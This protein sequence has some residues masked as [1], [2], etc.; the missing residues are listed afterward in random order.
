MSK[1][2]RE[3]H[4]RQLIMEWK[5]IPGWNN[6]EVSNNG[7]IRNTKTKRLKQTR[8]ANN[9][10]EMVSLYEI[11]KRKNLYVHRIVAE[12]FVA[13]NL[14]SDW[15]NHIDKNRNNNYY[16]NLEWVTPSENANHR[17]CNNKSQKYI[18]PKNVQSFIDECIDKNLLTQE[19]VNELF[20]I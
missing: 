3:K 7:K 12:C 20:D 2:P 13:K 16:K 8:V 15:V 11:N 4:K 10:Y 17:Y 19:E 5:K 6:H 1:Y 14:G 9:G 18:I